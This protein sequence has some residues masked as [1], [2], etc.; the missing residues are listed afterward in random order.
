MMI[1][2]KQ[3]DPAKLMPK[4]E[5]LEFLRT[6]GANDPA[7]SLIRDKQLEVFGNELIWRYPISDGKHIGTYIAVVKEGFIS[8]PYDI[9]DKEEYELLELDDA[10]TFD[11]EAMQYFIDDW[12]SF[13]DDLTDAMTEMLRVL[14]G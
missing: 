10:A 9:I 6:N 7:L 3:I 14:R 2:G 1:G 11:D 13:S 8:L 12:R 5:M 4:E